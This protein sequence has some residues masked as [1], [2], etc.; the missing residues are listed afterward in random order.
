[1]RS[2]YCRGRAL[3]REPDVKRR[4]DPGKI[5][6]IS[7]YLTVFAPSRFPPWAFAQYAFN[8]P[9]GGADA[10]RP[11][12]TTPSCDIC[13]DVPSITIVKLADGR[14]AFWPDRLDAEPDDPLV[15]LRGESVTWNNRTNDPHWPWP[16]DGQ[17]QL[18]SADDARARN[19]YL[20]DAIPA[21][22]VSDP[23]YDAVPD[24]APPVTTEAPTIVYVC[25]R[26]R[27]ER[28]RIIVR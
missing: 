22:D 5:H 10:R 15:I 21:G 19:F 7:R 24:F 9:A 26:H 17:G 4:G 6:P 27:L 8:P 2:E 13:V 3:P 1:M 28:G 23:S 25:R 11:W 16:L 18:L 12:T 20:C 14:V